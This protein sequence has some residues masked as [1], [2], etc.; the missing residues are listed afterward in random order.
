MF[1]PIPGTVVEDN[2]ESLRF[3]LSV[4]AP[5]Q[6]TIKQYYFTRIYTMSLLA[7]QHLE[8]LVRR[9]PPRLVKPRRRGHLYKQYRRSWS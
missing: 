5:T 4:L 7:A 9:P 3:G 8:P 2:G 1:D 6:T